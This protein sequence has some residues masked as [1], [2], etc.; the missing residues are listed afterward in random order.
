[1]ASCF[2]RYHASLD[3]LSATGRTAQ[4]TIFPAS[5]KISFL[6]PTTLFPLLPARL[7]SNIPLQLTFSGISILTGEGCW[8]SEDTSGLPWARLQCSLRPIG[9]PWPTLH[10]PSMDIVPSLSKVSHP[11][12]GLVASRSYDQ[13]SSIWSQ[14]IKELA[15]GV[16]MFFG[17]V[18]LASIFTG[19][20]CG[21]PSILVVCS[22]LDPVF[23]AN[24]RYGLANNPIQGL[25]PLIPILSH[26]PK[27]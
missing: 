14:V 27:S 16:E 15:A 10:Y 7:F 24:Y 11:N 4:K 20:G 13:Q 23:T 25:S 19:V 5:Q 6:L 26:K 2:V 17:K 1:M 12:P 22:G 18:G 8:L 3:P 21:Y 9:T